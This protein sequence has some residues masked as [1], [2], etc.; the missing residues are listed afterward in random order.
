MGSEKSVLNKVGLRYVCL[1]ASRRLFPTLIG[2]SRGP[3]GDNL[4]GEDNKLLMV[5]KHWKAIHYMHIA[6]PFIHV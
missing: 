1:N 3:P 6:L 4:M 5:F 2:L